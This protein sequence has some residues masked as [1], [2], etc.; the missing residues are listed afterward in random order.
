MRTRAVAD[1]DVDVIV[2]GAGFAGMTAAREL[3]NADLDVV[4]LEAR[5]RL[6]GRTW[7]DERLGT[8]VELGGGH[9]HWSQ[10]HVWAE[11]TR[12]GVSAVQNP[13]PERGSWWADEEL[14]T[15]TGE[16]LLRLLADGFERY[17]ADAAEAFPQPHRPLLNHDAVTR[18]DAQSAAARIDELEL[19]PL[20]HALQVAMW[21]VNFC[22]PVEAGS[23]AQALRWGALGHGDGPFLFEAL[24]DYKLAGGTRALIDAMAADAG[25][26]VR[27]ETAV[28]ELEQSSSRVVAHTS[29]GAI[30]ARAAVVTVPVTTLQEIEFRP[31]LSP[32]KASIASRGQVST[33]F[34]LWV[35]AHAD[36]GPWAGMAARPNPVAFARFEKRLSDGTVVLR[37]FG[38]DASAVDLT[39]TGQAQAAFEPLVPGIQVLEATGHD[40]IAD[41]YA[42]ETWPMFRRGQM[43]AGLTALQAREGR[44]AFAG[45]MLANGWTSFIDGAI[46]TGLTA[47][48][49]VQEL[50][51]A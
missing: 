35:R 24:D 4:V 7:T 2:V 8:T 41:P 33:G 20:A 34:K 48:R 32:E 45:A 29:T 30:S 39:D 15:G 50:I 26:E 16:Q 31:P 43:A 19:P 42:R 47:A 3:R 5:D 51:K 6:G 36:I 46:E 10:P 40:W 1:V 14:H 12:Y 18:L 25:A 23:L 27:L 9:V 21:S 38:E 17:F 37:A 13:V 28:T 22:G 44:V 11:M 49:E